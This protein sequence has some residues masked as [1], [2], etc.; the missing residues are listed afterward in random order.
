MGFM[1]SLFKWSRQ[2]N[3][4]RYLWEISNVKDIT[5]I[6]TK[7]NAEEI[8]TILRIGESKEIKALY[9]KKCAMTSHP[10]DKIISCENTGPKIV[11]E[12]KKNN[13]NSKISKQI[14]R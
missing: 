12:L 7:C 6:N 5:K 11:L 3:I 9:S 8:A 10:W 14:G 4:T 1:M 13:R 2:P